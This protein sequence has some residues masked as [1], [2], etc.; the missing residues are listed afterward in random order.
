M[1][2]HMRA[3]PQEAT[4]IP[5]G[6]TLLSVRRLPCSSERRSSESA[7]TQTGLSSPRLPCRCSPRAV[8]FTGSETTRS[9]YV[10]NSNQNSS[11]RARGRNASAAS[12]PCAQRSH[13]GLVSIWF[14]QLKP[15]EHP[16]DAGI[17]TRKPQIPLTWSRTVPNRV[18]GK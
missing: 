5:G 13:R 8:R 15:H 11:E 10:I 17:P 16:P 9:S 1:S 12:P 18:K 2:A 14:P 3:S 6:K 7:H 4:L